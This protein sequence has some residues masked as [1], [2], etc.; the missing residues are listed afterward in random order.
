MSN[1][2]ENIRELLHAYVDGELDLANARETELHLRSCADCR[3][4]EKA[5][6]ELRSALTTETITYRA[7]AH[8]RKNLRAA[9]RREAKATEQTLS[10]WL[11]FATGVAFAALILGFAFFQTT[12]A[13]RTNAIVDQVVANHVRS[14]LAVQ[15]VDVV[16]SNQHT[17]KPWFDGKIDFAPEVHDL[18]ANGFPLV[19][20]RLDYLD[21]KTVAALVYQRNK[22]PINLFVTPE[23]TTRSTSPTVATRRGYNVLSWTND[24]MKYWAVSDLNQ[25]ELREFTD[26]VRAVK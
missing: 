16:S 1:E 22:H 13:A 14:L 8:L 15:L 2:H 21:G 20:G 5:I 10:P 25:A 4:T 11:M 7:P 18:S 3:G 24:G 19:G 17:V 12:R 26:L 6:R 9:L 23:P